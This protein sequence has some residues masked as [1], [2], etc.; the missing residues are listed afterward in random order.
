MLVLEPR[1]LAARLAATYLETKLGA[2]VGYHVRFDKKV[3]PE[4]RLLF[5]TSG[6]FNRLLQ[7][8]PDLTGVGAV[9]V[10]EFHE[11]HLEGDTALALTLALQKRRTDLNLVVMS[12]TLDTQALAHHLGDCP[13]LESPGRV[14]PIEVRYSAGQDQRPLEERVRTAVESRHLSGHTLVFL[15]GMA[16]IRTCQQSCRHL[17]PVILHGSLSP[18]EQD[19]AL[20][21]S[22][23]PKTILS[24]NV[25]ESSVT[26]EGVTTV[27][28]SGLVRQHDFSPW[29]GVSR[30]LVTRTS[31]ASAEQRAG[32]AGRTGPGVAI[33]LYPLEDFRSRAAYDPP[34][35]ER[36]DLARLMLELASLGIH[37]DQLAWL[38]PPPK[39][40]LIQAQHLLESL[41]ALEEGQLTPSGQE[42]ARLPLSP[43]QARVLLS[44]AEAGFGR[45]G[46]RLAAA[47]ENP[48]WGLDPLEGQP[49]PRLVRQ[50]LALHAFADRGRASL[51]ILRRALFDGFCD[52]LGR[53]RKDTELALAGGGA[54]ELPAPQPNG[55]L[56]VAIE[57]EERRAGRLTVRQASPVEPEWVWEALF[58]H[59]SEHER[60]EWD[61][62]AERVCHWQE[63]RLGKLVL[64]EEKTWAQPGPETASVLIQNLPKKILKDPQ[65]ETFLTRL[66]LVADSFPELELP[67]AQPEKLLAQACQTATSLKEVDLLSLLEGL[68]TY[69]QR[70]SLD[71][72]APTTLSLPR[73]KKRGAPI[74]YR[75][76]QQP[77]VASKLQDFLGLSETPTILAGRLPLVIHLLAPNGRPAQVTSDLAGF[78]A[79]SYQKV[80]KDLRG[81]YPKHDWPEKPG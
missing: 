50:L 4:T 36:A 80:R 16:E 78:W 41:G 81:R 49:D 14:Y 75:P 70:Q 64:E 53:V 38:T 51:G 43:R 69:S 25:A 45:E 58:D 61:P 55:S 12:A 47:L 56:M 11:R 67:D 34:E 19:L 48:S 66:K 54:A 65:L 79:G 42:M 5:V 15:P 33:R 71:R 17:N 57:C 27:V 30:L 73:R 74:H 77:Y 10:D 28:D 22:S 31:Q 2:K 60:W 32:R 76:H 39:E 18:D 24:T 59:L 68:L 37:P 35:I 1:R 13:V 6:I 44:C 40:R 20:R 46:C 72:L 63:V 9:V 52:R 7:S 26:V 23:Q 8:N 29:S 3:G 21:P 62:Q